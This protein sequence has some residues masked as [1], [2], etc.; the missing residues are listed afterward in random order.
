MTYTSVG[1]ITL[2][3]CPTCKGVWFD[4]GEIGEYLL[5]QR[6]SRESLPEDADFQ[7][8]VSGSPENC[9]CCGEP[10]FHLGVVRGVTFQRCA[11]CGG[12]FLGRGQLDELLRSKSGQVSTSD[13]EPKEIVEGLAEFVRCILTPWWARGDRW[14]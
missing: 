6:G 9:P 1:D 13:L 8:S 10:Q 3:E 5:E 4:V 14:D 2:D 12:I 7:M 11:W